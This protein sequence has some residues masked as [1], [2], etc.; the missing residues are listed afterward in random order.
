MPD[1][2]AILSSIAVALLLVIML[3][4]AI[5]TQ[6]NVS[7][8]NA[9]L[10]WLQP[11]LPALGQRTTLRWL[12]SS[13]VQLDF[14]EPLEPF[15]EV[16]VLVVLEPRDVPFMWLFTRARGR[17]DTLI[18]RT[19]LRRAPRMELEATD[20]AAWIKAGDAEEAAGWPA[21]AFPAGVVATAA[22]GSDDASVVAARRAWEALGSVSEGVWRMSIRRTVPHLELHIRPPRDDRA[23]P[24]GM[25]GAIRD[26]AVAL[27]HV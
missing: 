20:A 22:P 23:A 16:S 8:G 19:S 12:G 13:V 2:S 27:V 14:V 1:A 25:V 26:L 17:R 15:R 9:R 7:K 18:F 24:E 10:R 21:A 11:A 4:F 5:G 6:R 3:S